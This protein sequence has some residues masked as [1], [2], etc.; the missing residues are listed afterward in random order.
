VIAGASLL[1]IGV[2]V[3]WFM[4]STPMQEAVVIR[5]P[6]LF[7]SE[8]EVPVTLGNTGTATLSTILDLSIATRETTQIYPV[9]TD[10]TGTQIPADAQTILSALELRAPGSFTR[11]VTDI[12]FGSYNGTDPLS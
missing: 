5:I 11:A 1:G 7:V 12:T 9:I 4:S 8:V 6:S 2:S 10:A 3:Y